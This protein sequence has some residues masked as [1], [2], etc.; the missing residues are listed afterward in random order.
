VAPHIKSPDERSAEAV[1]VALSA[2]PY[3][4]VRYIGRGGMGAV[5]E[6]AHR[7]IGRHFVL[8]VLHARFADEPQFV[9]RM[10]VEAQ[11]MA[12]LHHP[13]VVEVVDFWS[14][15]NG[16]PC[17]VMELLR[18]RTLAQ[19]LA[20]RRQLPLAEAIEVLR[21]VLSALSAAHALG[22]VHRDIKPENIFLHEAPGAPRMVK[23]LDFGVARVL[24]ESSHGSV[25]PLAIPTTTGTVVG[26]PRFISPE[27]AAGKKVDGRADLY[28]AGVV[29]YVMM[30]GKGPFDAFNSTSVEPPSRVS[31]NEISSDLD[32]IIL[33]SI[34]DQPDDRYQSAADFLGALGRIAPR[35]PSQWP[36]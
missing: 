34:E 11:A 33:K 35:T 6:V 36:R 23:V 22:I 16:T 19:E 4:L 9:D 8:K 20:T 24:F 3:R 7:F 25:S 31:H 32:A 26:S 28:S 14:D 17:L 18:G 2:T 29:A 5:Y 13:N 30:T 1:E 10:R 21:Q 12:R 15:G 27:G